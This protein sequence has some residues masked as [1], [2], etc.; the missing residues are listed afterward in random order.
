LSD[1]LRARLGVTEVFDSNLPARGFGSYLRTLSG[2][3]PRVMPART[4]PAALPW[5]R[6]DRI[7]VRG[8]QIESAQVLHGA[9]WSKLSVHASIVASLEL[10]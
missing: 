1:S 10:K 3:G 5:L 9:L 6:L 4:F 8:L 7:Y 2:R